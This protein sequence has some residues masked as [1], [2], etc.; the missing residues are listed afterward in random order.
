MMRLRSSSTLLSLLF[1]LVSA[2]LA[3]AQPKPPQDPEN[4]AEG[5]KI[6][7]KRCSFCHGEQGNGKGPAA[8]YLDPRPRDFTL[9]MYKLRTTQ[10]G[11][12]PLD[13]D[14]FR[15]IAR[16]IPGTA[17]QGFEGLLT[18][19]ERWQ[20][21]YFIK[22]FAADLFKQ[23]PARAEIGSEKK[24][25]VEK[26][27]EVYQR[28]KCWECHGQRG[29]GDGPAARTLK[30][31][32][33]F[34]ILPANLTKGWRFKGGSSPKDIFTRFT[35]GMD[36]TPMPSFSETLSEEERWNLAAYVSSLI[37]E[38]Q[39]KGNVVLE[40]KRVSRDLPLNPEDALWQ[41]AKPLD[42]PLSGQV[43]VAP[44]W[45]NHSVDLIS[46]RSL[47]NDKAIAFLLEWDDRFKDTVHKEES[48]SAKDTYMKP[49]PSRKRALRDSVEIQFPLK[50]TMGPDRPYFFLGQPGNPV[51]LWRW[52]AD[53][54][55]DGRRNTA[56]EELDATGPKSPLIPQPA[57]GQEVIGKGLW[58]D[59]RWRVVMMRSLAPKG[60]QKDITFEVG[61][62]VPIAFHVWDGSNGE[63]ELLC[64]VSSW[65]Y[66]LMEPPTSWWAYLYAF[67]GTMVAAVGEW[68]LVKSVKQS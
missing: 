57:E 10:S 18:E 12:V 58:K 32:R 29:R 64:A 48:A 25:S 46:V 14:L 56:V 22:T 6:Y 49:D 41:E 23:P 15:V 34:P 35:T 65:A 53:W 43:V 31:D 59:G 47:Y 28:A 13:E 3:L 11:E 60:Q 40:S 8:D 38:P 19:T 33:G 45:Q 9:G 5:K 39:V 52:N 20:V 68:W 51:V 44:R 54:N 55:E 36:G 62:T 4:I 42:V 17:M 1:L 21:I 27:K 50:L 26:G 2:K 30:D 63:R 66:L 37:K 7:M 24:G 61:K 16:G 67:M